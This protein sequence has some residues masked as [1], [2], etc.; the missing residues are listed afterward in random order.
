MSIAAFLLSKIQFVQVDIHI[1]Q[2][3]VP[4]TS[5]RKNSTSGLPDGD[6]KFVESQIRDS[7][8]LLPDEVHLAI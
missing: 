5:G 1:I 6:S 2:F 7:T 3:L 4:E 8:V